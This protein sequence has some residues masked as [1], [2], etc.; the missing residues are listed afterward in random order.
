MA[1]NGLMLVFVLVYIALTLLCSVL[2]K[3]QAAAGGLSFG[4]LAVL[5]IIGTIPG[6]GK[7]LPGQLINWGAQIMAGMDEMYWGA[8]LISVGIIAAAITGAVLIFRRQEI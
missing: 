2:M 3:T 6:L 5:G 8:L 1:L 7:Y 4:F